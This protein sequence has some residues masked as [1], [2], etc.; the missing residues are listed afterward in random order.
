M[1]SRLALYGIG[2]FLL[3]ILLLAYLL[4]RVIKRIRYRDSGEPR[5]KAP[6][7]ASILLIILAL[8]SIVLSQGFFWLS[9]QLKYYRPLNNE[10]DIGRL[11]VKRTDDQIKSLEIRY[12]PASGYSVSV[13]NIVYLSGDSWRVSGEILRFKFARNQFTL[14]ERAYKTTEFNGRFIARRS[15]SSTGALLHT[16]QLEGGQSAVF[17]FFRDTR[18]FKWFAEVDSFATDW[19]TVEDSES[20]ELIV[21][22]DGSVRID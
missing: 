10:G 12:V 18:L 13:E 7:G 11:T 17:E 2:L 4:R 16:E 1:E 20:Y 5:S 19:V 15:P 9:S 3:G 8:L 6:G 14:P 22:K 21:D